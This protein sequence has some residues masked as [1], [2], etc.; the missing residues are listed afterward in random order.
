MNRTISKCL[1]AMLLSVILLLTV[2]CGSKQEGA[3]SAVD[4]YRNTAQGFIDAGDYDSAI[5]A[6]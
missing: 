3:T 5:Q 4:I 2:S 6:L 1:K